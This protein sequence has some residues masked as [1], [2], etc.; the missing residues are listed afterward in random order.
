MSIE[1]EMTPDDTV[2]DIAFSPDCA[3]LAAASWDGTC[4]VWRLNETLSG[5]AFLYQFK[6]NKEAVLRLCWDPN[7][8]YVY[9]ATSGGEVKKADFNNKKSETLFSVG[10]PISGLKMW[11][12]QNYLFAATI[13]GFLYGFSLSNPEDV[14]ALYKNEKIEESITNIDIGTNL[15][16][17]IT[18]DSTPKFD[19][20]P[21]KT[22]FYRAD[23]SKGGE[24]KFQEVPHDE[25]VSGV[26]ITALA[27]SPKDDGWVLGYVTGNLEFINTATDTEPKVD[28]GHRTTTGVNKTMYTVNALAFS[29]E[30]PFAISVGGDSQMITI[31]LNNKRTKP[32]KTAGV[33]GTAVALSPR[34]GAVALATGND[35]QE[36]ALSYYKYRESQAPK[37]IIKKLTQADYA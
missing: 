33:P 21:S 9:Y 29:P 32:T 11:S 16:Y 4:R 36:G 5:A 27:V 10:A 31:N 20:K 28:N 14:Q 26:P 8:Q 19:N 2:S 6:E 12:S 25:K 1:L 24:V 22:K 30:R 7:S 34:Q 13:T 37:I 35:W 18:V 3:F 17:M 15:L 23:L